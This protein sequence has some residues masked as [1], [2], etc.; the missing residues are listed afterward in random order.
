MIPMI[1]QS[2]QKKMDVGKILKYI[3]IFGAVGIAIFLFII[4]AKKLQPFKNLREKLKNNPIKKLMQKFTGDG[5]IV[6]KMKTQ[7]QKRR[8]FIREGKGL[9]RFL[10]KMKDNVKLGAGVRERAG[11]IE[12]VLRRGRKVKTRRMGLRMQRLFKRKKKKKESV[13]MTREE[14]QRRR[15]KQKGMIF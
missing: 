8:E 5:K 4:I 13:K 14:I 10:K 7:M 11:V 6:E 15:M 1:M 2:Q 3:L 9:G 12:T